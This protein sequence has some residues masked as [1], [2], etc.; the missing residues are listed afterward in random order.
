MLATDFSLQGFQEDTFAAD[1]LHHILSILSSLDTHSF[2]LLTS[3]SLSNRS[4]VKDLWIFTGPSSPSDQDTDSISQS[5]DN[6][7]RTDYK[8]ALA[9]SP[10]APSTVSSGGHHPQHRRYA[11]SPNLPRQAHSPLHGKFVTNEVV[12]NTQ[13]H[14]A[15]D[16]AATAALRRALPKAQIPV[17]V[18]H[19]NDNQT[20]HRA[21]LPSTV[22]SGVENMTGIGTAANTPGWRGRP[23]PQPREIIF[24]A[25]PD[26][27]VGLHRTPS[28]IVTGPEPTDSSNPRTPSPNGPRAL[29]A[30][31]NRAKTPPL[32]KSHP[33][34]PVTTPANI[35]A[36]TSSQTQKNAGDTP[37]T[38]KQSQLSASGLLSP[39]VFRESGSEASVD[40]PIKWTGDDGTRRDENGG[41]DRSKNSPKGSWSSHVTGEERGRG[42]RDEGGG[43]TQAVQ[44]VASRAILPEVTHPGQRPIKSEV[45]TI[46]VM[47]PTAPTPSQPPAGAPSRAHSK[48]K[49][50]AGGDGSMQGWVLVNVEGKHSREGGRSPESLP[51][52][53]PLQA[54]NGTA[55]PKTSK[56]SP[57]RANMSAPVKT[58]AMVDA[59]EAR[60]NSKSKSG[61]SNG[62]KRLFGLRKT[63]VS[64]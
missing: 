33:S 6:I 27:E 64:C 21:T 38:S 14:Q 19:S 24:E 15:P 45:G 13:D 10:E 53:A 18:A 41:Q 31:S 62:L 47:A 39:G 51:S 61:S 58:L 23:L 56:T 28:V 60:S 34:S 3:I 20:G 59:A 43:V 54:L 32:L 9:S 7:Y 37:T 2:S 4:R 22:S 49:G 40:I 52:P 11:T 5:L 63:S 12:A 25:S 29:R 30:V 55:A 44:D 1:S 57:S 8:R 26:A 46:G 16:S 35:L 36:R 42:S 48:G 17:S 50:K